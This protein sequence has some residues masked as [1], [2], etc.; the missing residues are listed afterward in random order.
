MKTICYYHSADFDGKC[1]AAVVLRT[2]PDVALIGYNYQDLAAPPQFEPGD[3]VVMVDC[4][5]KRSLMLRLR[6][7]ASEFVWIDHHKT[8]IEDSIEYGYDT[9]NG[10]RNSSKAACELTWTYYEHGATPLI[11]ELLGRYDVFDH[12]DSRTLPFQYGSRSEPALDSPQ[13]HYY[14]FLFEDDSSCERLLIRGAAI[15]DYVLQQAR[16]VCSASGTTVRCGG[17]WWY[18]VNMPGGNSIT[19]RPGVTP[20]H[21]GV[22]VYSRSADGGWR[23]GLYDERG[24]TDC[25]EVAKLFGG[26]GH[27]KAAGFQRRTLQFEP[28][29]SVDSRFKDWYQMVSAG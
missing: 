28:M 1:S 19:A 6:S 4:S 22:M 11:V 27:L 8:A 9:I 23:F 16:V 3:K 7:E 24:I 15:W 20:D 18:A 26:G 5:F 13:N 25:G 29:T 12:T 10:I 14:Q 17:K 2:I 21:D